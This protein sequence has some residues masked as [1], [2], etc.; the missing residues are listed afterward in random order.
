MCNN[1]LQ[2]AHV[3]AWAREHN[4]S[5]MSMRFSYKY[6]HFRISKSRYVSFTLYLFVKYMAALKLIPTASFKHEDCDINDLERKMVRHKHIVVSGWFV[7][8]YDLFLKYR[9]EI[10]EL[11]AIDEDI[12]LPVRLEMA[13]AEASANSGK[14]ILRLGL[15]IRRGDYAEWKDGIYCYPDEYYAGY[16]DAFARLFPDKEIHIYLSS[17]DSNVSTEHYKDISHS[18]VFFHNLK[19]SAVGD[20]YMLSKCDYIIGPPST[21]SLVASMYHDI[22]LCR[23]DSVKPQ[24]LTKESFKLFDY[25]FRRI[26]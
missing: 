9:S 3:Y 16:V 7:R 2:F 14:D 23:M 18:Q 11:F 1:L 10:C 5:V 6:P 24:D 17:N 4:R 19:G 13:D 15:H 22:P 12:Y 26:V 25:W 21:F 8:F 20:L